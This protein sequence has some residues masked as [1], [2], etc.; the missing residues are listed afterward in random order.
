MKVIGMDEPKSI[1]SAIRIFAQVAS[2]G[3]VVPEL[4]GRFWPP[5]SGFNGDVLQSTL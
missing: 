5:V 1:A 4:G 2:S 3:Q